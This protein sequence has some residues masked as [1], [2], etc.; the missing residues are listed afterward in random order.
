MAEKRVG[1]K[2]SNLGPSEASYVLSV[3]FQIPSALHCEHFVLASGLRSNCHITDQI[4]GQ[5]LSFAET[6]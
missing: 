4:E 3:V 2:K 5:M 6:M 1:E